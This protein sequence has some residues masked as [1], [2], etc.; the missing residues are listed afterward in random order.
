MCGW[1][2]MI[3]GTLQ[4]TGA[5]AE[6][7]CLPVDLSLLNKKP[8]LGGSIWVFSLHLNIFPNKILQRNAA[9]S[10]P[11][12]YNLTQW[13]ENESSLAKWSETDVRTKYAKIKKNRFGT[14]SVSPSS[15]VRYSVTEKK[16]VIIKF[17]QYIYTYILIIRIYSSVGGLF[18]F[19]SKFFA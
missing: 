15:L 1:V 9:A 14:S 11:P 16:K 17:G 5:P 10:E 6:V 8:W 7:C 18:A 12:K 13:K 4:A 3:F 2:C 19:S